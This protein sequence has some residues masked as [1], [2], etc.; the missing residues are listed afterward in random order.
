[1]LFDDRVRGI[2]V[3]CDVLGL[4][5]GFR[6][7]LLRRG[8]LGVDRLHGLIQIGG[9]RIGFVGRLLGRIGRRLRL[10]GG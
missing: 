9:V 7:C 1:M 5:L 4:R 2:E 8:R 10:V 6:R 3:G